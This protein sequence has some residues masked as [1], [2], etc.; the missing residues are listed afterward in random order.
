MGGELTGFKGGSRREGKCDDSS[1]FAVI[2]DAIEPPR[3]A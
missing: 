3:T 1:F 2:P